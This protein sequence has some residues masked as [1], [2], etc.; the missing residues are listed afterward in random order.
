VTIV[1]EV[2]VIENCNLD[3]LLFLGAP[4]RELIAMLDP[5]SLQ[6]LKHSVLGLC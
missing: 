4:I 6:D 2:S 5:M 1:L 3:D